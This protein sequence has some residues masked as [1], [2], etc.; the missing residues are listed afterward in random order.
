MREQYSRGILNGDRSINQSIK[1]PLHSVLTSKVMSLV[2][3][4]HNG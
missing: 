3:K 4:S 2:S 1:S